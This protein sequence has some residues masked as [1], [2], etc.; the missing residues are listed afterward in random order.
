MKPRI[1]EGDDWKDHAM[2]CPN[3]D[4]PVLREYEHWAGPDYIDP[5]YW[6]CDQV[7]K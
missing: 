7:V 1:P 5:G 4:E 3:C 2:P 6:N